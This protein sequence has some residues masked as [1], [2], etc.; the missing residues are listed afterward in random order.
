M[1]NNTLIDWKDTS[2]KLI[3]SEED[4]NTIDD[5][6]SNLDI[7]YFYNG[8]LDISEVNRAAEGLGKGLYN[9]YKLFRNCPASILGKILKEV[10]NRFDLPENWYNDIDNWDKEYLDKFI[11]ALW[12]SWYK[13]GEAQNNFYYLEEGNYSDLDED[14]FKAFEDCLE[15]WMQEKSFDPNNWKNEW[16]EYI[17]K[18]FVYFV[19]YDY[20]EN[21]DIPMEE[22]SISEI[23]DVYKEFYNGN[24]IW[25]DVW[26]PENIVKYMIFPFKKN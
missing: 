21:N 14:S 24:S 17:K 10:I 13:G 4:K 2:D 22:I 7:L 25:K 20:L 15:D 3:I 9:N 19:E 26:T 12:S 16:D 11:K 1:L 6:L 18:G 8:D 23:E 5:I